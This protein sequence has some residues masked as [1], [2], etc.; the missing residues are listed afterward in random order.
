MPAAQVEKPITT[1]VAAPETMTKEAANNHAAPVVGA[2]HQ[3]YGGSYL[4]KCCLC[5]CGEAVEYP[6]DTRMNKTGG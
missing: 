1:A 6:G 4:C 3:P 5:T 2:Q